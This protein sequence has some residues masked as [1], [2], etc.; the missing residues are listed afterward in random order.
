MLL[1]IILKNGFVVDGAG[2]PK[3][4]A[5]VGVMDGKIVKI[6]GL[7]SSKADRIID[8]KGLVVSP[9]F[10][11]VH[12]HSDFELLANPRAE[13]KIRQ[14][15]TTEVVGNCGMSAAP[16]RGEYAS[17]TA[18]SIR[19]KY[20]LTLDWSSFKEYFNRLEKQGVAVNIISLVGHGN[21]RECV[22]DL[23]NRPPTKEEMKEMKA[24][25]AQAMEEGAFG[26][27][28]GLVYPPGRFADTIELI[29][30]SKVVA[31]YG[32][33]YASHIRGERETLIEATREAIE[34]GEKA[35][36]PVEISHHPAKIGAWGKSKETLKMIEA[37]RAR[38]VDVTCDLHTYSAGQ[39]W[40]WALLPPWAQEGG[41]KKIIETLS[42][43]EARDRIKQDMVEEKFPGPGPCGLVKR[44][45]WNKL[46]LTYCEKNKD[47]IGKN[48]AEI[49]KIRGVDPFDAVFDIL[50]EE[51]TAGMIVGFYYGVEDIRRVLE[52]PA[53][54]IGSDGYALAPYGNLG[55]GKNHPRSYGTFPMVLAR[56]VRER[57]VLTLEEA[58]RKMT[59]L[60]AQKL[61]LRDRGLLREGMWA[62]IVMF[63]SNRVL[64]KA[65]YDE[66][67]QYPEG[68]ENVLVDGQVVIEESV[69]T[70]T[71]SGK[72]LRKHAQFP[73][74]KGSH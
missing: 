66:P 11:D 43:P 4:R 57:K 52:H 16:L 42:D 61:G 45:M 10:I 33:I 54:M 26:L 1:D 51:E 47:L 12:T 37:A 48:F 67:Y 23:E 8:A 64:D 58:V 25:V 19:D 70:G 14:G 65:T 60:P 22:M 7:R 36:V 5:D 9:G 21:I 71:L 69:H 53:S 39:T 28:T 74:H 56:Y 24:L 40:L 44:G 34:I 15:V 6:G 32:G 30:F 35:G 73:P 50:I 72:V 27:S 59:S 31:K 20:G 41:P 2:N 55:K 38:G 49:A 62:D 17:K 13:S 3:F 68:I 29:E 63:D 18:K 46:M